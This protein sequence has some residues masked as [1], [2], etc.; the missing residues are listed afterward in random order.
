MAIDVYVVGLNETG[1]SISLAMDGLGED[2]VVTGFDP[3]PPVSRAARKAGTVK[4][5]SLDMVKP[6]RNADLVF[7]C[8]PAAETP[9]ALQ[10][11]APVLKENSI[12]FDMAP[13]KGAY[14]SDVLDRFPEGRTYVGA[15]PAISPWA[16][17]AEPAETG[18][19]R[20]DLFE[21]GSMALVIAPNTSEE[22]VNRIMGVVKA[23]G[24]EPFFVDAGEVD[25]MTA[26]VRELPI[27]AAA[28]YLNSLAVE[29]GW[30]E[31]QRLA[32]REFFSLGRLTAMAESP[33]LAGELLQNSR[34][35][36]HR[37]QNLIDSLERMKGLLE[38]GE[39]D[40]LETVLGNAGAMFEGWHGSKQTRDWSRQA[41][42][43]AEM[44]KQSLL[45]SLLGI[46]PR[47][48]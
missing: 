6:A 34:V 20:P 44:P 13:L 42:P 28:G 14:M 2:V 43:R 33:D 7:L 5:I 10:H 37:L 46:R 39:Q 35:V 19:G 17:A 26:V 30:K 31:A 41:M 15:V 40:E 36:Q 11:I 45:A 9:D 3:E 24:A 21:D 18:E 47:K 1:C 38:N 29:P 4:R 48:K 16:L 12:V 25:G 8:L 23:L 27:L 32:S 22:V